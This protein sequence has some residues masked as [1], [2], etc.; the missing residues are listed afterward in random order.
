MKCVRK[1]SFQA[2]QRI[3]G[4]G[5]LSWRTSESPFFSVKTDLETAFLSEMWNVDIHIAVRICEER[6]VTVEGSE[7]SSVTFDRVDDP[8]PG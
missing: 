7:N 3:A 8:L 1:G 6:H 5:K 2:G 4:V